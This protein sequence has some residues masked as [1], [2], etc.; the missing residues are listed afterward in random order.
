MLRL[1]LMRDV[2]LFHRGVQLGDFDSK[3]VHSLLQ[4]IH[5]HVKTVGFIKQLSKDVLCV[6]TCRTDGDKYGVLKIINWIFMLVGWASG[7][8]QWC[9]S[10]PNIGQAGGPEWCLLIG[11]YFNRQHIKDYIKNKQFTI[12]RKAGCHSLRLPSC[13]MMAARVLLV[14]HSSSL[15][16]PSGRAPRHRCLGS[17]LL[18]TSGMTDYCWER[19]TGSPIKTQINHLMNSNKQQMRRY[20]SRAIQYTFI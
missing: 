15:G 20:I 17:I 19:E 12:T 4:V 6:T 2:T 18:F 13:L 3:Q 16:T 11:T 5:T 8:A 1:S 9:Y 10:S 7:L 14:T